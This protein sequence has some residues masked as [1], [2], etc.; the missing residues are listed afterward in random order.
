[1]MGF[2]SWPFRRFLPPLPFAACATCFALL[3]AAFLMSAPFI[4]S[5]SPPQVPG[6]WLGWPARACARASRVLRCDQAWW[7]GR[8]GL[9]D[10]AQLSASREDVS[11]GRQGQH[12]RPSWYC[13]CSVN[14]RRT[15]LPMSPSMMAGCFSSSRL[16][17]LGDRIARGMASRSR[18]DGHE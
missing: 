12:A 3:M 17:A 4:V 18:M 8:R 7:C 1:M 13:G 2:R 14:L 11:G 6:W 16:G 5:L 10:G 15:P 9:M